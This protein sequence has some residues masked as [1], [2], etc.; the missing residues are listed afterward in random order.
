MW[1]RR[2][3]FGTL[4]MTDT[5]ASSSVVQ[6]LTPWVLNVSSSVVIVLVNKLLMGSEG[7]MFRFGKEF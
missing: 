3:G 5:Q 7:Y 6:D 2:L 1:K 4:T